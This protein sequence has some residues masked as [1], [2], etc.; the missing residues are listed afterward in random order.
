MPTTAKEAVFLLYLLRQ[1]CIFMRLTLIAISFLITSFAHAQTISNYDT[2]RTSLYLHQVGNGNTRLQVSKSRAVKD[3][4]LLTAGSV[5]AGS[6]Q[7]AWLMKQGM[8]GRVLWQ[9]EYGTA[10]VNEQFT[11]WRELDDQRLILAGIIK[12]NST[13]QSVMH[14]SLASSDGTII[15]QRSY[16]DM[17]TGNIYNVKVFPDQRGKWFFAAEGDNYI[18]YGMIDPLN[19][20]LAWQRTLN[21]Q[22]GT[23]L[24]GV[25][26]NYS[27]IIFATNS[28]E[29]G[30]KVANFYHVRHY[31]TGNPTTISETVQLGGLSQSAHY[32]LHDYEHD[33]L[34]NYFSGIRSV[35]NGPW[36]LL[37]VNMKFGFITKALETIQTPGII[38]DSNTRTATN[39]YGDV[40]SFTEGS[41]SK[42]LH[43]VKLSNDYNYKTVIPWA[44]SF[45]FADSLVLAGN[46]KIWDAGYNFMGI[47]ELAGNKSQLV[48]LKTDSAA[49]APA[50]VQKQSKAFT[51]RSN[52][53]PVTTVP[54]SY[55][56]AHVLGNA[57]YS[58]TAASF[59]ADTV[60]LCREIRCPVVPIT[61]SCLNSFQ[62]IYESYNPGS[63]ANSIQIVSNRVFVAGQSTAMFYEVA[64]KNTFVAEINSN[65]QMIKQRNFIAGLGSYAKLFKTSDNNLMLYGSTIDSTQYSSILFAKLDTNLSLLWM[66]SLR[67]SNL[68][69]IELNIGELTESSDGGFFISYSWGEAFGER[70]Q[71][72]TKISSNGD[73]LWSKVYRVTDPG[74]LNLI[75]SAKLVVHQGNVYMTC[76]NAYNSH[77]STMLLKINENS[78]AVVWCKLYSHALDI[79]NLSEF[80][81]VNNNQL[82]LSGRSHVNDRDTYDP[83]LLKLDTD[84]N[85]LQSAVYK[86]GVQYTSVIFALQ[87]QTNGDLYFTGNGFTPGPPGLNGTRFNINGRLDNNLQILS[88]R[89]RPITEFLWNGVSALSSDGYLYETGGYQAVY[90][91]WGNL[92]VN[93][94]DQQGNLGICQVDTMPYN[95][96]YNGPISVTNINV[97]VSDSI[98]TF[99]IPVNRSEQYFLATSAMKCASVPG[100]NFLKITGDPI[101]CNRA[102]SYEYK[103]VRNNGCAAPVEWIYEQGKV[104]LL[105]RTDSSIHFSF[106]GTGSFLLKARLVSNCMFYTD[107]MMV[108][109]ISDAPV[110]N[111]G[112]DSLLCPNAS[113]VLNAGKGFKTYT[114]QDGS[115]D[116]TFTVTA[117]GLYHVTVTDSCNSTQQDSILVAISGTSLALN[118]GNDTSFCQSSSIV[119]QAQPGFSSYLWQN[120]SVSPQLTA[121]LPGKYYVRVTDVCGIFSDTVHIAQYRRAATLNLGRDTTVCGAFSLMLH[122][123]TGFRQYRWQDGSTGQQLLI[124]SSGTYYVTITDSC[125]SL[126]TD[127]LRV[128]P[129]SPFPFSLGSNRPICRNDSLALQATPG[130]TNYT[131]WPLANT[132]LNTPTQ[133]TVFPNTSTWYY[134]S[135]IKP[136]GCLAKDS[137]FIAVN[138]L[139]F[140]NIGADKTICAGD[141]LQLNAGN[142]FSNYQWNTGAQTSAIY[143]RQAGLYSVKITDGNGCAS[144]DSMRI[145]AV[146]AL[147]DAGL[148]AT[149]GFC[150]GQQ[151]PLQALPGFSSYLWNNGAVSQGILFSRTGPYWVTVSNA[152]GCRSTDTVLVNREYAVPAG[153][154]PFKDSAICSYETIEIAASTAFRS[155]L[156]SDGK[157]SAGNSLQRPGRYWLSVTD[158]NGCSGKDSLTIRAKDC[159]VKIYF[160]NSFTPNNDGLNDR[161]MP[162]IFGRTLQYRLSIYNRYGQKIFETSNAS[163]GWD[164]TFKSDKQPMGA[165]VWIASYQLVGAE[166]ATA[167]GNVLLLR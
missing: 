39:L 151:Q 78:G 86:T 50:C 140:V 68:P 146:I 125:G 77:S 131:W 129:D 113:L 57:A 164:G 85:I 122:A 148:P 6:N 167:K 14:I 9:K 4:G 157:T 124:T 110:L 133:L 45:S 71:Y 18:F 116:S 30:F 67:I 97:P 138:P 102:N 81:A 137:I 54:Y 104:Q 87:Q 114:W 22:P 158:V 123:G 95:I 8:D 88:S 25:I 10:G 135:A 153:F 28:I 136:N 80:L 155:Y 127:T 154:L 59:A 46:A 142:G 109:I 29:G 7:Q 92:Y 24:V 94:Y 76:I 35:N 119:L 3:H 99:R 84:G 149:L 65:G 40:I 89:R 75:V 132:V 105:Y 108:N 103:A 19:G 72:L 42:T 62:K 32:I 43:A 112:A 70:R 49:N 91:F 160:P 107:S 93:K 47:K 130:L 5:D 117:A 53:F 120:G 26:S 20:D 115:T 74:F 79:F 101:I 156:W 166:P 161:F 64:N 61:D 144:S 118:L 143:V 126:A 128:L 106:V 37:R 51:V 147:P 34:Y 150:K 165:Y 98:F 162:T 52:T 145:T 31:A 17:A 2:C 90:N 36:E 83:T 15:W 141:S 33:D 48:Q 63:F 58:I 111:L 134:A 38:L 139:P 11:D 159:P 41:K 56:A 23:K 60:F 13:L 21:T 1:Y 69:T 55:D 100:C 16:A 66:K 96:I 44:A 152:A 163:L 12:N 27:D 73:F 121:T 82:F